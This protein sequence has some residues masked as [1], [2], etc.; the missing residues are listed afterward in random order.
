M[1]GRGE[2][3]WT[4]FGTWKAKVLTVPDVNTESRSEI[5][6]QIE[7]LYRRDLFEYHNGLSRPDEL[8]EDTNVSMRVVS[9][10]TGLTLKVFGVENP[11]LRN[12]TLIVHAAPAVNT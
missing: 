5:G 6:Y 4:E 10:A 3:T 9:V 1:G 8:D 11:Q 7:G 12:R 2:P